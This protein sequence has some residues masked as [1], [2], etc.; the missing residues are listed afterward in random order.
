MVATHDRWF[1]DEVCERVWEVND[2]SVDAY[3]GGYS[4]YVLARAERT[5]RAESEESRRRNLL[6]KELAWLQRGPPARTSK[7][8]FR[9]DAAN[10]L[11]EGEP[12]PRDSLELRTFAA[13][14]L[15]KNVFD[16]ESISVARGGRRL[17]T[18][19]TWRLG[20]GDRIGLVGANGSGKTTLLRLLSGQ[21]KPDGGEIRRGLTVRLGV[22]TQDVAE[23][24]PNLRALEAVEEAGRVLE[25]G[26]GREMTASALLEQF[27]LPASR[28]WT[29]VRDLSGGERR[30]LA[31]LRLLMDRPNVLLLD[32]P[33][34]DLDVDTLTAL[35]DVLDSWSGTLV[36]VSHDRYFL[37]RTCD[38]V[39]ALLGDGTLRMMVGG[40]EEYLEHRRQIVASS[41]GPGSGAAAGGRATRSDHS[42][43]DARAGRK[44]LT[45]LERT[46]DRLSRSELELHAALA[47]AATDH[48]RLLELDARLREV[49]AEKGRTE[50]AWLTLAS[51][52]E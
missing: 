1:L 45:R 50:E 9:I 3:D 24:N 4:A 28:Q 13:T 41:T 2:G 29:F 40:V 17:L 7:P 48:E 38:D 16:A 14:R 22:L 18:D 11:I 36:V 26:R 20:P 23:I 8:R 35:E 21:E 12:P 49:V 6:R 46:L 10:A 32:E 52:L 25:V 31:L 33:T 39:Q 15:G 27:G 34:N 43:A 5:R 30:R 51:E 42:A 37:E 47:E 19:V 44:E